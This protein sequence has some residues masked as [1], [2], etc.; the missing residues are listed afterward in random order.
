[1]QAFQQ[2]ITHFGGPEVFKKLE[3]QLKEPGTGELLIEV[4]FIGLNYADILARRGWYTWAGKPPICPGFEFSGKIIQAGP[5]TS[6][7]AGDQVFGV[8][9]FGA[10]STHLIAEEKR[11]FKLPPKMS[12]EQAAAI[13]AVYLT[14]WHSIS[15]I[16]RARK[17][18]DILIQA[19][20]GGVGTAATQLAKNLGLTIYGTASSDE[21]L[22]FARKNGVDYTINYKEKDFAEE[23]LKIT[24]GKGIK[25]VLDS[26]GGVPL[27]RGYELLSETGHLVTIGGADIVPSG[28]GP[29]GILGYIDTLVSL[30]KEG[31]FHPHS[32]I[33]D[34]KSL[35]GVQILLLWDH[36]EYLRK[37]M[38]EITDL[39]NRGVVAPYIDK[40]FTFDEA[41]QAQQYIES[42]KSRGKVLLKT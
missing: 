14:A 1:M 28:K 11:V 24:G 40:I 18:E 34:N 9:K 3:V 13:P 30:F 41:G 31:W 23:I 19:A 7:K 20:A 27:R 22:E 35:S 6:M 8:V 25:Y 32:M 21:K 4:Q 12:L 17:G 36:L 26:L 16:M 2:T 42:R 38:N 39:F 5:D 15:E 33:A 37:K 29:F 10:Y